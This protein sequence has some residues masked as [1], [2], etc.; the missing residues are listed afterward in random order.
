MDDKEKAKYDALQSLNDQSW[1]EFREKTQ[2]EWRLSFG[3]WTAMV[4]AIG[5]ILGGKAAGVDIA[6]P[7]S[8]VVCICLGLLGLHLWFLIWIQT[9]LRKAREH[10]RIIRLEMWN[11]L[12]LTIPETP[13]KTKW[14]QPSL[15]VQL[16]ITLVLAAILLSLM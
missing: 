14:Q 8:A 3:L 7:P 5:S 2:L 12:G 11:S 6:S 13:S 4:T 9:A 15:Y 10:L 1:A 16:G